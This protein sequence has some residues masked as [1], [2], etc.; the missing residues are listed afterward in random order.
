M[1]W[2]TTRR[3]QSN[4]PTF[5]V[6]LG[7]DGVTGRR[8]GIG[9]M[10][11]EVARGCGNHCAIPPSATGSLADMALL[12]GDP[13][14]R[15]TYWTHLRRRADAPPSRSHAALHAPAHWRANARVWSPCTPGGSAV[16]ST[17]RP[18]TWH[19]ES[20]ARS[21]TTKS[22]L[23][24]RPF[25]GATVVTMHDLSWRA[26]PALHP[27]ERVSMDRAAAAGDTAPGDAFRQ[28]VGIHS[29]HDGNASSASIAG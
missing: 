2:Q 22:N 26:D 17:I 25:D 6:L 23:I 27:P 28:C 29:A 11:L 4:T 16:G 21:S 8:S 20:A 13:Y 10:T 14:R 12:I 1:V 5:G 3:Q 7:A 24:A 15:R 19:G 18:A 9:R